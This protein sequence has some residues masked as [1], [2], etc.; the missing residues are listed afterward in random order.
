[1]LQGAAWASGRWENDFSDYMSAFEGAMSSVSIHRYPETVCGGATATVARLLDDSAAEGQAA[2][3]AA[4]VA[5]AQG[6]PLFIG[7]GNSVSCG[8]AAGVSDVWASAL[9]ALDIL[10]GMASVGVQRWNFHGMPGGPYAVFNFPNPSTEEVEVRPIFYGLL[11]FSA[12][13]GG[14]S[15][16]TNVTTVASTNPFIKCWCVV[17]SGNRAR[18]VLIHKD[19]NAT[20]NA[21]VTVVPAAPAASGDATLARGLPD[22]AKG[23]HSKWNDGIS[24]GGQTW[25]TTSNGAPAGA[26]ATE[27]VP[28]AGGAYQLQ[29]PPG[30]FAVL[31]LPSASVVGSALPRG[32][33]DS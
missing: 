23:V 5:R 2:S 14:A 30:S 3:V 16:I 8:G 15:V 21:T 25:A 33:P 6:V 13:A 26:A 29:L 1:M 7:E 28:L 18:V 12:A 9:W 32:A 22:A 19:M 4:W 10:F 20:T 11:A 17:D 27:S 24:W 31:S